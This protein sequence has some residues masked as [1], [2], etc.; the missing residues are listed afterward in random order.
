MEVS[1]V[2]LGAWSWGDRSGYWGWEKGYGRGENLAAY[3]EMVESTGIDF[4]D[5]AGAPGM[6]CC[7]LQ[8]AASHF[9]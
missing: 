5:T 3:K 8:R 4:L 6:Q 7:S 2:G 9:A 1:S